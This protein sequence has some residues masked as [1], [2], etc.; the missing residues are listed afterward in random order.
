M[1]TITMDTNIIDSEAAVRIVMEP[2]LVDEEL[3]DLAR[4]S[5]RDFLKSAA[6]AIPAI[7]DTSKVTILNILN[8]GK[9]YALESA[10]CAEF[11]QSEG[12]TLQQQKPALAELRAKRY[13]DDKTG[14]FEVR[15]W[16]RSGSAMNTEVLLIGFVLLQLCSRSSILLLLFFFIFPSKL[17]YSYCQ[18]HS[19][20]RCDSVRSTAQDYRRMQVCRWHAALQA[21]LCVDNC[22]RAAV[23]QATATGGPAAAAVRLTTARVLC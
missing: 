16:D 20:D 12:Q 9:Y 1:T 8:G 10:W 14:Q 19:R 22:R 6:E 5:A 15:I 4:T 7:S 2:Y 13:V 21:R 3:L 17:T 11:G 18:R 23:P